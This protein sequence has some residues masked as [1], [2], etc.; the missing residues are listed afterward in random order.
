M[1]VWKQFCLILVCIYDE[2]VELVLIL[3]MFVINCCCRLGENC[4]DG[5]LVRFQVVYWLLDCY[6]LLILWCGLVDM[7]KF[8]DGLFLD[9]VWLLVNE[10]FQ[11]GLMFQLMVRLVVCDS[12]FFLLYLLVSCGVGMVQLFGFQLLG[13]RLVVV[14]F[15]LLQQQVFLVSFWY[16]VLVMMLLFGLKFR[17]LS[18]WLLV[19][20]LFWLQWVRF[21]FGIFSMFWVQLFCSL[22]WKQ[23]V[24]I[25]MLLI[26]LNWKVSWLFLCLCFFFFIVKFIEVGMKNLLQF[27]LVWLL[28]LDW[29]YQ[30]WML[31]CFSRLLLVLW[32]VV[33]LL[34]YWQF[35]VLVFMVW[36]VW[37][38]WVMLISMLKCLFLLCQEYSVDICGLILWL[39]LEV[40]FFRF[41]QLELDFMFSGCW[42]CRM[43]VLLMLFLLM[44]VFGDL[45][46][47]VFDSMFDGSRV[48]L[49]EWVVLLLVF[50]EVMKLL[51][52]WV[53]VRFGVRLCMLIF[54]FLLLLWVMI[55]LGMCCSVLV[56]F[57]LGNL[58]MFLVVII[59]IMVLVL[60]FCLR[61]FLMVQ[62]QLVIWMLFRVVVFCLLVDVVCCVVVLVGM[63]VV[64][65]VSVM[66]S[67]NVFWLCVCVEC[68]IFIFF[69]F[70][71]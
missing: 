68:F 25:V 48:Q 55:M 16:C 31:F 8:I 38:C 27:L 42:V 20:L 71:D 62:W 45:N 24:V 67:D 2:L 28:K 23:L 34:Y 46:S 21:Y 52:N 10:V 56:M 6:W 32:V 63:M 1:L 12:V 36:V 5:V 26:G 29:F 39:V 54:L 43:I 60:C 4:I 7:W 35:L 49:K 53:R 14:V 51:F 15:F 44:C 30:Q 58:L 69:F 13:L 50:E 19:Q 33:L 22:K 9:Q 40:V 70:L 57:L 64:V 59:L 47:L 17:L 18:R 37:F 61:F 11:S 66:V 41:M 3:V 65:R